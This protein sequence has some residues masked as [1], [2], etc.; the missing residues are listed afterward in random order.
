MEDQKSISG[1][2][3]RHGNTKA[4][5]TMNATKV[6]CWRR[7]LECSVCHHCSIL[8]LRTRLSC[9]G[10]RVLE[11]NNARLG[12][13]FRPSGPRSAVFHTEFNIHPL[14]D[15][16]SLWTIQCNLFSLSFS[17]DHVST[18]VSCNG[19]LPLVYHC[20]PQEWPPWCSAPLRACTDVINPGYRRKNPSLNAKPFHPPCPVAK[21]P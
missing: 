18:N 10:F 12:L 8:V 11:F 21:N 17:P 6:L 15:R 14:R 5:Y 1:N 7:R 9:L 2:A 3:E 20:C 19:L 13:G 4:C 16:P